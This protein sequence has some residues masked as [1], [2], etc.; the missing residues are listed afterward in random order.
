MQRG[1]LETA[2]EKL[3]DLRSGRSW[4]CLPGFAEAE[5]ALVVDALGPALDRVAIARQLAIW[6]AM[7]MAKLPKGFSRIWEPTSFPVEQST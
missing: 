1:D 6:E 7:R 2:R 4:W 5:V 3:D